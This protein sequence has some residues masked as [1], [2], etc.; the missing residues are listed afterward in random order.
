MRF[1]VLRQEEATYM[2]SPNFVELPEDFTKTHEQVTMKNTTENVESDFV[3]IT[4]P[5][6]TSYI[7][8]EGKSQLYL[9]PKDAAG[10][11]I[12]TGTVRIYKAT[13]DKSQK[14][15]IGEVPVSKVRYLT[16]FKE[17]LYFIQKTVALKEKQILL[18][19]L[20]APVAAD[21]NNSEFYMNGKKIVEVL[22]I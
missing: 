20:E 15:K 12:T 9:L 17:Q 6:F 5:A 22:T 19:T 11:V 3:I 16:G 18:I 1:P 21:A 10:N 2:P 13:A 7:F 14:W 4:C 8:E